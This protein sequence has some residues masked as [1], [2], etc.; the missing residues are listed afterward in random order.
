MD[1]FIFNWSA[2]RKDDV[3]YFIIEPRD[4]KDF[5]Y[6]VNAYLRNGNKVEAEIVSD[7]NDGL[8]VLVKILKGELL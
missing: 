6:G 1:W 3:A 8:I 2:Y 4:S 7:I 5:P